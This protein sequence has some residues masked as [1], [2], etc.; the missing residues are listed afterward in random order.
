LLAPDGDG[1][2]NGSCALCGE[3]LDA[4][5]AVSNIWHED[6]HPDCYDA[7][8]FATRSASFPAVADHRW[9]RVVVAAYL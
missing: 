2:A 8:R 6:F 5:V 9:R 1:P 3:S 7:H 4:T